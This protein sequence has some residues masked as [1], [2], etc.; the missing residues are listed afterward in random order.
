MGRG[1]NNHLDYGMFLVPLFETFE[2]F[3]TVTDES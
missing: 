1:G 3:E 2:T